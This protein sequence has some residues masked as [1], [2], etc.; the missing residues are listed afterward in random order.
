MDDFRSCKFQDPNM[1]LEEKLLTFLV[2]KCVPKGDPDLTEDE[3]NLMTVWSSPYVLDSWLLPR[4]TL[5]GLDP[6]SKAFMLAGYVHM[7]N[8][9]LWKAQ[10]GCSTCANFLRPFVYRNDSKIR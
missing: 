8:C 3:N 6:T 5:L 7:A 9:P 1:K 10:T 2:F 4:L